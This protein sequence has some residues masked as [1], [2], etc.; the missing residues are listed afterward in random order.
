M[1]LRQVRRGDVVFLPEEPDVPHAVT[2]VI[3]TDSVGGQ[4]LSIA[5]LL[6]NGV[7]VGPQSPDTALDVSRPFTRHA[8]AGD[9]DA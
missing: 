9:H 5:L 1:A 6:D 7:G 4:P 2:D 8:E 3:W